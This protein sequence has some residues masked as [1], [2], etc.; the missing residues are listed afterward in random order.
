M[1]VAAVVATADRK[2]NPDE[3]REKN[4]LKSQLPTELFSTCYA[5]V[6]FAIGVL[7]FIYFEKFCQRVSETERWREI[8]RGGAIHRRFGIFELCTRRTRVSVMMS[9]NP[10]KMPSQVETK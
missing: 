3:S 7:Q 10:N 6:L 9:G 8:V 4:Y 1:T 2:V 5:L